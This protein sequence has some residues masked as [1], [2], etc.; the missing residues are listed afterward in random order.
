LVEKKIALVGSETLLGREVRDIVAAAGLPISLRLIATEKEDA[1]VLTRLGDE[2]AIVE[3]L[4]AAG[5][6]GVDALI[7]AG[8]PESGRKAL[9]LAGAAPAIDLTGVAEDRPD[10]RLRAPLVEEVADEE[11]GGVHVVAHPAAIAIAMLLRRLHAYDPLRRVVAQIFAPAS[12]RGSAGIDELQQQTVALLSFKNLP[13]AVY[14]Q[15]AAFN[16]LAK[17]GEEA[18]APLEDVELRI[19]RHL[20]TLLALPGDGEGAPMPSLRVVQAPVFHGYTVS[21]WVEFESNPGA[22]AVEEA[23]ESALVEVRDASAEPPTIVGQAGLGGVAVGAIEA[24][25]N[26]PEACW[27]WLVADNIRLQAENAVALAHRIV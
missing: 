3:E 13:K 14:D 6:V 21:L 11:P 8:P 9:E 4:T 18:P 16:L 17:Y 5:L 1:G 12:E 23:L 2:P 15:Q 10:A 24:D 27:I 19:E 26:D 22:R 20:A 7:L 25:R